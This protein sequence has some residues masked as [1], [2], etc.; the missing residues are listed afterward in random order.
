MAVGS[1]VCLC[2]HDHER[3]WFRSAPWAGQPA[4]RLS[5]KKTSGASQESGSR[6]GPDPRA[7]VSS[8]H[9]PG[10]SGRRWPRGHVWS[11]EPLPSPSALILGAVGVGCP[12]A[13]H[14]WCP[15]VVGA[16]GHQSWCPGLH[17]AQRSHPAHSESS[18]APT[19][20]TRWEEVTGPGSQ[21][22]WLAGSGS[23]FV[24]FSGSEACGDTRSGFSS[25]V[26]ESPC[27]PVAASPGSSSLTVHCSVA[28]GPLTSVILHPLGQAWGVLES[29]LPSVWLGSPLD[30]SE[31][32]APLSSLGIG[33]LHVLSWPEQSCLKFQEQVS[34]LYLDTKPLLI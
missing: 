31:G 5:G 28:P 17:Q 25:P 19:S 18:Q 21:S 8:A 12:W 20:S 27:H 33:P 22:S 3:G 7:D 6:L 23:T 29:L 9:L 2:V 1:R 24:R 4:L 13:G 30:E 11:G 26:T 34:C 15:S 14:D 10:A 16:H 32:L